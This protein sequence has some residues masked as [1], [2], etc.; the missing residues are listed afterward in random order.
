MWIYYELKRWGFVYQFFV[1]VLINRNLYLSIS[2]CF[3][4]FDMQ[5]INR[6]HSSN[7]IFKYYNNK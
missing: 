5:F 7:M 6:F 2:L 4:T 1:T 3:N